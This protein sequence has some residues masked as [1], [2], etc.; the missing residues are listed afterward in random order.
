MGAAVMERTSATIEASV[1]AKAMKVAASIVNT[2]QTIPILA[3]ARLTADPGLGVLEIVTCDLDSELRL[4]VPMVAADAPMQTTV[5]ARR[6][7]ALA[8]AMPGAQMKLTLDDGRLTVAAGRSRWVLPVLPAKDFPALPIEILG[9]GVTVEPMSALAYAIDRVVWSVLRDAK[10]R[11]YLGGVYVH[12]DLGTVRLVATDGGVMTTT[13]V[14]GAIWPADAKPIIVPEKY[15]R[16][17][18]SLTGDRAGAVKLTWD[19]RKIRAEIGDITLTGKLIDYEYPAY[20]RVIPVDPKVSVTVDPE[21]MR[22]AA[23]RVQLVSAGKTS[24][25][26]IDREAGTLALSVQSDDTGSGREEVAAECEP[27]ARMGLNAGYLTDMAA[28]IGGDNI[29]MQFD[30]ER[31]PVLFRRMVDDGARGIVMPMRI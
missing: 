22:A 30:D 12:N 10:A 25:V 28:A 15:V 2:A 18:S 6:L 26:M 9:E 23:R 29:L 8:S 19:E 5:D 4:R 13:P 1:L 7:S 3:N 16:T 31:S 14:A 20:Q 11:P 27:G 24:A 21:A 17:L